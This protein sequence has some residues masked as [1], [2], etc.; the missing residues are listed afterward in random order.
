VKVLL[1]LDP[2]EITLRERGA[3]GPAGCELLANGSEV[4][5]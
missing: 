1:L 5:Q 3:C 2:V 4:L